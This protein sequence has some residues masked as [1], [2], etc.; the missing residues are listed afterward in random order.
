MNSFAPN[1]VSS[2]PS[3]QMAA[4]WSMPKAEGVPDPILKASPATARA[5]RAKATAARA[6]LKPKRFF[7]GHRLLPLSSPKARRAR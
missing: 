1:I 6:R 5:T 7:I 4:I 2:A 3:G